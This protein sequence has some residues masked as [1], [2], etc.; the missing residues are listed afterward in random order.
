MSLPTSRLA[1]VD[2]I[3][4]FD[5]ALEDPKGIRVRQKDSDAAWH[6]R[7]RMHQ[8][9]KLI[10]NDNRQTYEEDHPMFGRSIYDTLAIRIRKVD[11]IFYLYI[12]PY[13]TPTEIEPLSE[14]EDEIT[15]DSNSGTML[16]PLGT[17]GSSG[18]RNDGKDRRQEGVDELAIRS[19]ESKRR[20]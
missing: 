11:D 4:V 13:A 10:Q 12:A 5:R 18:D 14:I 1:F 3:E 9:R 2:C 15:S 6:Y 19:P 17:S 7:M 8:A 20:V 16:E